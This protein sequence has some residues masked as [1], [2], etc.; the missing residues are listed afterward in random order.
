MKIAVIALAAT[1]G[2]A[3]SVC[4]GAIAPVEDPDACLSTE[5][6]AEL[7]QRGRELFFRGGGN[8]KFTLAQA[9]YREA[10]DALDRAQAELRRC[11]ASPAAE[12][13]ALARCSPQKA[14]VA[15]F[16]QRFAAAK[17]ERTRRS[18]E[19]ADELTARARKMREDY[20]P[21]AAGR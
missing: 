12:P 3:A 4:E 6:R 5:Q 1:L 19:M 10:I 9:G 17:A 20:P 14:V 11:E 15:D 8:E 7:A 21:C 18:V 2:L 13:G 16:E